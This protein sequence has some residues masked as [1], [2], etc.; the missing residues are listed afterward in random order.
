MAPYALASHVFVCLQD[1]HVV[2]LDV[3]RDRYFALE[4]AKTRGLG[5]LVRGWPVGTEDDA[6]RLAELMKSGVFQVLAERGL[7]AHGQ[8]PGKD[9]TPIQC[10]SP[11]EEIEADD[12]GATPA[13]GPLATCRFSVAAL[14]ASLSLR[15]MPFERVIA[16]AHHRRTTTAVAPELDRERTQELIAIF[17]WLRPFA[18][19]AK[20]ACLFEALALGNFLASHDIYPQWVF[21]VQ[22]RPFSAHCWLQSGAIVLNDS[23][24][25]VSQYTPIMVA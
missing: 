15:L 9:A 8:R 14:A 7:L 23:V 17:S 3:R 6:R 11:V 25:H 5:A 21:G 18:F 4:A 2:F 10:A 12:T 22:A 1:E 13:I 24:E 19:T 16:R 20:D